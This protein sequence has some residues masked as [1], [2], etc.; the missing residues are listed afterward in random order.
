MMNNY[1]RL[2]AIKIIMN[3]I[4]VFTILLVF[5][6]IC[7]YSWSLSLTSSYNANPNKC[8]T[9]AIEATSSLFVLMEQR[10]N[11]YFIPNTNHW[12]HFLEHILI[13]LEFAQLFIWSHSGNCDRVYIAFQ[14]QI[15]ATYLSSFTSLMLAAV[16]SG[17]R[18][19][20]VHIGYVTDTISSAEIWEQQWH[21]QRQWKSDFVV[22][23][24]A[25][26]SN[27]SQSIESSGNDFFHTEF[28]EVTRFDRKKISA[29]DYTSHT[30]KLSTP[31]ATSICVRRANF[32][33]GAYHLLHGTESDTYEW[34]QP[35][36][37]TRFTPYSLSSFSNSRT[38][39]QTK[40]EPYEN[41]RKAVG[42]ICG[43][44]LSPSLV[45]SSNR[46]KTAFHNTEDSDVSDS[47][48]HIYMRMVT[49]RTASVVPL[50]PA[51]VA[52]E[53]RRVLIYQRDH[54][55]RFLNVNWVRQQLS[56]RLGNAAYQQPAFLR[57]RNNY[58]T[59]TKDRNSSN[60]SIGWS[61]DILLHDEKRPACDLIREIST[62]SV[63]IT[64]HGFQSVL[65]LFQPPSSYLV[66]VHPSHY[67]QPG[68]YGEMTA[69]LRN[70]F[71]LHRGYDYAESV[72]DGQCL[73]GFVQIFLYVDK[74]VCS[75]SALRPACRYIYRLQHVVFPF[76]LLDIVVDYIQRYYII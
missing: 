29:V 34:F 15:S 36:Q 33:A 65:L 17:G 59:I 42:V 1:S 55:R 58:S 6:K 49:H 44:A 72:S 69:S 68:F 14:D 38:N 31:Q 71:G 53:F 45:P 12:F 37:D 2:S 27:L 63:L 26:Q 20:T 21:Y 13:N 61:V 47:L 76:E 60:A 32:F 4:G 3:T 43:I 67:P 70:N 50:A 7:Y 22:N 8:Y 24:S 19:R 10:K 64:P 23:S 66:E 46:S 75:L 62:A 57:Q 41:F 11:G 35:L 30:V 74:F 18:F 9:S 73:F 39:K 5:Y 16:F 25:T 48:Q 51:T 52:T 40:S 54:S 28:F 56:R